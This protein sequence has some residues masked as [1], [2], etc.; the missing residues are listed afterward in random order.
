MSTLHITLPDAL[1][2]F[3]NEQ[4]ARRGYDTGDEYVR[5]L[6]RRDQ[7]RARLRDLL[8]QGAASAPANEADADYFN[9]LR[10]RIRQQPR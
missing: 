5:E 7:E 2:S 10:A 8:L 6:I 1:E 9:G 3:V 4:V